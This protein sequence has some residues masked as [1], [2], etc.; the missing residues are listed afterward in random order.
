VSENLV[1]LDSPKIS[2]IIAAKDAETTIYSAVKS[3][4][5]GLKLDDEVLVL[6]DGC[7]DGT[8]RELARF[9]DNRL[10][11]FS[12]SKS[13]GRARARNYLIERASGDVIA[14]LDA[15]DISL[16]W[17]FW[18][19][20]RL[21]QKYDAVFFTAVVFGYQLRPIPV[22][23]QVPRRISSFNMAIECLGRN[24]I[25]HSSAAYRRSAIGSNVAYRDSEAEEY[26][27]WLRMLNEGRSL[28]RSAIPSVL[29]RFHPNQQS[30]KP[31]FVERG[32][33]CRY[34]ISEQFKL[35]QSL[36]IKLSTIENVRRE[37][38]LRVSKLGILASLEV[39]GL[40]AWL[41]KGRTNFKAKV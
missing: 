3:A 1:R 5:V 18:M 26:D 31:G 13:L 36:G 2:V 10:F 14:V 15:D 16:P 21:I 33:S 23:P 6:L 20:R 27:L 32:L 35:A 9:S 22:I 41:K 12:V 7:S 29:Y 24:P 37:A 39:A 40:P 11:F 34:V 8:A 17:R 38:V 4:L 28:F 25:V 30:Q 19:T